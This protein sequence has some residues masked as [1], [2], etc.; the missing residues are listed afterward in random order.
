[1]PILD[2]DQVFLHGSENQSGIANHKDKGRYAFSTAEDVE[3]YRK[4]QRT[5][6]PVPRGPRFPHQL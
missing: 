4:G 2:D 3:R 6:K 5:W 1:M